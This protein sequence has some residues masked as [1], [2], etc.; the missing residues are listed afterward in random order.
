M[1]AE[2]NL[3]VLSAAKAVERLVGGCPVGIGRGCQQGLALCVGQKVHSVVVAG[4]EAHRPEIS[5]GVDG[6]VVG[7]AAGQVFHDFTVLL[8]LGGAG[9]CLAHVENGGIVDILGGESGLRAF[10]YREIMDRSVGVEAEKL[11]GSAPVCDREV[12]LAEIADI[13]AFAVARRTYIS[14]LLDSDRAGGLERLGLYCR[15]SGRQIVESHAVGRSGPHILEAV[16]DTESYRPAVERSGEC[17]GKL[18]GSVGF[19]TAQLF[20]IDYIIR[21]RPCIDERRHVGIGRIGAHLGG[22]ISVD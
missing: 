19:E 4:S 15:R 20:L 6:D 10:G 16:G 8:N 9:A 17:G 18:I 11:L 21:C 5:L 7:P 13:D 22:N 14:D 1:A 3:G 12:R 2:E